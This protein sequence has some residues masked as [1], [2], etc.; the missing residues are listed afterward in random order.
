MAV[1]LVIVDAPK[2][3]QARVKMLVQA[4]KRAG[5]SDSTAQKVASEQEREPVVGDLW[6]T[7]DLE[8]PRDMPNCRNC[9]D[10]AYAETCRA[11]GHCP[12]CGVRHAVAP[13]SVLLA[14]G[15]EIQ[16]LTAA[17]AAGEVWNR[18]TRAFV[19]VPA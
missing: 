6:G 14:H 4:Y 9:G 12:D 13:D 19:M 16:L 18:D 7:A 1:A 17:P 2:A 11:A 3:Y 15:L 8:C 10:P 5:M